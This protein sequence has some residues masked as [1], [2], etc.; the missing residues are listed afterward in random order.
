M[1]RPLPSPLAIIA[2]FIGTLVISMLLAAVLSPWVQTLTAALADFQL[3]RIFNRLTLVGVLA[4]T[5]WLLFRY[6]LAER[7]L[8]G[9]AGPLKIFMR[10]FGLSLLLGLALMALALAPLFALDL[11]VWS[12]SL[13]FGVLLPALLAGIGSGIAVALIEETFFRG[14]LQGVLTRRG[15]LGLAL[16]A[17]PLFYS[18]V[19]FFGRALRIPR[20]EVDAFSGFEILGSYLALFREPLLIWD[21]FL[22]LYFVGL[23]L[24]IL[25]H[26]SG[27]LASSLGLHAG[28]VAVIVVIRE[29]SVAGPSGK[30]AFLVG[31]FDSLLGVWIALLAA[32]ACL[33]AWR[34]RSSR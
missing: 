11:R 10:Q 34:F 8:L 20:A 5:V 24:A 27:R 29:H 2:A 13:S 25:R 19:H 7:G 15:A 12:E 17:V 9:Y 28:F 22:A 30:A 16:F 31:R 1:S 18:A 21:A 33:I 4:L 6:G 14:A 32:I 26:R 23:L 3:H